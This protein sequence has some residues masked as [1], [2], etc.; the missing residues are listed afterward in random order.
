M[1]K[2]TDNEKAAIVSLLIEMINVDNIISP[3]EISEINV[4]NHDLHITEE[5]FLMGKAL[6]INYAIE[7][8]KHMTDEKKIEVGKCI[9]R[10]IDAD[11]LVK[12]I[13][14]QLLN[15]ICYRTGLDIILSD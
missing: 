7:I 4:I 14:I 2:Y 5:V 12:D 11:G 8:V 15:D 9:T 13:E 1:A 3:S 6:D 10:I